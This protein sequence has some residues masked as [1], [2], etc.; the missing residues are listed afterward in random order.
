[1]QKCGGSVKTWKRRWF[2]LKITASSGNL[3]YYR[4]KEDP[5]PAGY[6]NIMG[7]T[8]RVATSKLLAPR[9]YA[10]IDQASTILNSAMLK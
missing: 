9:A 10:P 2:V 8:T 1:M 7:T 6:I 5:S 4:N 3:F